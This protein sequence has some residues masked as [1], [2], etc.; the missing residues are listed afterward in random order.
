ML[1]LQPTPSRLRHF[2]RPSSIFRTG[3]QEEHRQDERKDEQKDLNC[4]SMHFLFFEIWDRTRR[5]VF[6]ADMSFSPGSNWIWKFKSNFSGSSFS[7]ID[8][9]S[10][11]DT[12]TS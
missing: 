12:E 6:S 3:Y 8:G 7:L 2:F 1:N 10:S 5:A 9:S 11:A 4:S